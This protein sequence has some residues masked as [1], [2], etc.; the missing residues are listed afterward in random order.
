METTNRIKEVRAAWAWIRENNQSIPDDIL[1][2]MKDSAIEKI[3]SENIEDDGMIPIPI[4]V[5][6]FIIDNDTPHVS[7]PDGAYYHYSNVCRLLNIYKKEC[8][9]PYV[10]SL[11]SIMKINDS[12]IDKKELDKALDSCGKLAKTVLKENNQL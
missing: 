7:L 3:E 4:P 8:T 5:G 12:V 9:E 2:L 6:Q 1:D 11:K 10:N